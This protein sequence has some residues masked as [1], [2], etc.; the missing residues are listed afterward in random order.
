[1]LVLVTGGAASGKSEYAEDLA[2]RLSE[3]SG[4]ERT[5]MAA[6]R[7]GG[8]EAAA[9]I[10]KHRKAR[11]GK[12]FQTLELFGAEGEASKGL[13]EECIPLCGKTVLL[14]DLSNLLANLMFSGEGE[15]GEIVAGIRAFLTELRRSTEHLVVV[16]NEIFSDGVIYDEMT[17]SFRRC[18]AL[19]NRVLSAEADVVTEVVVGIP[20]I[21]K[22]TVPKIFD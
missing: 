18:L 17:E 2:E 4:G 16:T 14:E 1:M 11:E 15:P 9:R 6:M 13:L 7:P 19:L 3:K 22:G 20:L 5:Y 10:R 21:R 12:G 8:E